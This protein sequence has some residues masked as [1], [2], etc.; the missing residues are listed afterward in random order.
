MS[1]AFVYL[2]Q[3]AAFECHVALAWF[4]QKDSAAQDF[5]A[6]PFGLRQEHSLV[7]VEPLDFFGG[8]KPLAR[9]RAGS[10]GTG[11]GGLAGYLD[12]GNPIKRFDKIE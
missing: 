2:N 5:Y 12:G 11:V 1:R 9:R 8:Q 7:R 10:L 6:F 4:V 3:V